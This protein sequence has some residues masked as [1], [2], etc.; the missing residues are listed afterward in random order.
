MSDFNPY[1]APK[2]DLVADGPSPEDTDDIWRDG[3]LLVFR[4]GAVL[5][6]RCLKCNEPA[7]GYRFTR[8]V[9]WHEPNWII[10]ILLGP[11]IYIIVALCIRKQAKVSAGLCERHRRLRVRAIAIGWLAGLGGIGVIVLGASNEWPA[12]TI[13]GVDT[14]F[15][16]LIYG[17]VG[18]Q[19][20]SPKKIDKYYVWLNKV[21]LHYRAAFSERN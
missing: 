7:G 21:D 11:L 8:N 5:P 1:A 16:G 19:V 3:K 2:T 6:D 10:L 12:V 20:F 17:I 14:F 13:A 18:S 4:K 9:S 15:F